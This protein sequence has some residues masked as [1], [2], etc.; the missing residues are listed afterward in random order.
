MRR[1]LAAAGVILSLIT[2][3]SADAPRPHFYPD[4][5]IWTLPDTRDATGVAA[6]ELDVHVDGLENLFG[7]PGDAA[8][9]VPARNVNTLDEVPDTSWFTNRAGRSHLSVDDVVRGP[10]TTAGPAPGQWRVTSAK[11]DG[12][13]PGFT[14]RDRAGRV[15]F[16]KFDP[17]D[18]R[19]MATGAEVIATK[20]L[21]ALGYNVPENH[22]ALLRAE[23]LVVEPTATIR[24]AAGR[25]PFRAGDISAV[26]RKAARD[27]DGSYRVLA[28]RRIDGKP[29]GPFRFYGVRPD[30]PND[31][32][33]HEHR[34]ELRG[35]GT[36]AAWLNH[37]DSKSINTF[38]ALVSADGK[39]FVKHYLLDFGSTLGS[40]G[41]A[42]RPLAE[43]S[44]Y[45]YDGPDMLKSILS[46]GFRIKPW[47][48]LPLFRSPAAGALLASDTWDPDGWKPRYSN[49]SFIRARV[50]DKFWAARKLGALTR[51]HIE[52]AVKTAD[53]GDPESE[54][55][56]V[57]F[58]LDRRRA[59]LTRYLVA[60]NP[61][62]DPVLD[63]TGTL[64]FANAAVDADA[65]PAPRA[66]HTTWSWFDNAT[67]A[68]ERIGE[69]SSRTTRV[70]APGPLP[71]RRGAFLKV[72]ISAIGS[73]Y[74]SWAV[75]VVAYFRGEG[76]GW[77]L[78]GLERSASQA[79]RAGG[80]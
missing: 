51:E 32:I 36:F 45:L 24:T 22:I 17:P 67:G 10:N 58:L 31:Y 60:A 29:I 13:M 54:A 8:M 49:P 52:A 27:A 55:A 48:R 74:P 47:R 28:S 35:Y 71:C 15:W 76:S 70:S 79:D 61:L 69:R 53:Y 33:P 56:V 14:V 21:W 40:A 20:L 68:T 25:R 78:V 26:L 6:Y 23:D 18:Y 41:V 64:T 63:A 62:V 7:R 9:N 30:D 37:V 72:E 1:I 5:P 3:A 77:R 16:L 73:R 43:G 4:D 19:G 12:V 46:L 80:R 75:P 2:L 57:T 42:P 39:T 34:R 11:S 44:E 50:E 38:D 65:A 59:I 66:Y